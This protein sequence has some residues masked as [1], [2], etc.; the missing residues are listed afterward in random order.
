MVP[1]IQ[2]RDHKNNQQRGGE[3]KV[4]R[5]FGADWKLSL[6][7]YISYIL[8]FQVRPENPKFQSQERHTLARNRPILKSIRVL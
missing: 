2:S 3:E 1:E 5:F 6:D 4:S 8:N 7:N